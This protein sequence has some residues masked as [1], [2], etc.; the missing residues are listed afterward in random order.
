LH[1]DSDRSSPPAVKT[2]TTGI[3]DAREAEKVFDRGVVVEQRHREN[4]GGGHDSMS[5]DMTDSE[6]PMR[7]WSRSGRDLVAALLD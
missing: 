5:N 7:Y 3:G 4:V 2:R 6:S 1:A